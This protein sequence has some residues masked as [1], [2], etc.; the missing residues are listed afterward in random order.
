MPQLLTA[1]RLAEPRWA[2]P[3]SASRTPSWHH[4]EEITRIRVLTAAYGT[5]W[6]AV[7]CFHRAGCTERM[8]KY[9]AKRPA[10]NISSLDSHTIVPTETM[11]GRDTGPWPGMERGVPEVT[12]DA[13]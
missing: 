10:K 3:C 12:A 9:I 2:L 7:S 4:T 1:S 5:L 8:V 13:V 11:F 6:I